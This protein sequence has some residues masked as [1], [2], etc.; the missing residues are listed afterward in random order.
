MTI[1]RIA[2]LLFL[3]ILQL[4]PAPARAAAPPYDKVAPYDLNA[5]G[6]P[7]FINTN[8]IDLAEVDQLTKFRSDAGHDYSDLTQFNVEGVPDLASK[9]NR[10]SCRSMKHYFYGPDKGTP[11]YAP[12]AGTVT[13]ISE[14][15]VANDVQIG[16]QPDAEPAFGI[17]IFHIV[18]DKPL[19]VGQHLNE[20]QLIGTD[21]GAPYIATDI[22]V[23]VKTPQGLHLISYFQ[24]L[25]DA[26]FAPYKARGVA[27][28]DALI[29]TKEQRD[30]A[31]YTCA[32]GFAFTPP[33]PD[34][35]L[36]Y[37]ALSGSAASQTISW[38]YIPAF[39]HVSDPPLVIS[40]TA[41]SGQPVTIST[42]TPNAC[43]VSGASVTAVAAGVCNILLTQAGI[44]DQLHAVSY[45][46]NITVL[47]G[48]NPGPVYSSVQA[49][50]QSYLRFYNTGAAAGTVA[51]T[52]FDSTSGQSL[53]K[54]ISPSIPAGAEQQYP[55]STL[56]SALSPG[57]V[58]PQY[59]SLL[60]Q[61][62]FT[63]FFQHVLW[64][65]T[66]GVYT[67]LTACAYGA[68]SDPLSLSGVHTSLIGAT[69]NPSS[70]VVANMGPDAAVAL[71]IYDA[72]SGTMLGTYKTATIPNNGRAIVDVA[73][74]EAAMNITPTPGMIHY[75]VKVEGP[76]NGFLQHLV[77]NQKLGVT[78][79]M[80]RQCTLDGSTNPL[81][82]SLP[83][84]LQL[85]LVY[86]SAN[87][88]S[89]SY[90][91]IRNLGGAP[92]TVIVTLSDPASG[93]PLGQ[94][95]SPAIPGKYNYAQQFSVA[96]MESAL[97]ANAVKPAYYALAIQSNF[98][99]EIQHLVWNPAAGAITNL[100]TCSTAFSTRPKEVASVDSSLVSGYPSTVIVNSVG[101]ASAT[102]TYSIPAY[103]GDGLSNKDYLGG[104]VYQSSLP[105]AANGAL[106]LDTK[107]LEA[108]FAS[109]PV[110][111]YWY[112]V[113]ISNLNDPPPPWFLENIVT[114][115]QSGVIED[116]TARCQLY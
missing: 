56:E 68:G 90:L 32:N 29:Y 108:T 34:P 94:W 36:D 77:L 93:Q 81:S 38:T 105:V 12:V 16:I 2:A 5:L 13:S 15:N 95:T 10:E 65:P 69:G 11:M 85:G 47:A 48:L 27:S 73:A 80:T 1:N 26:A 61:A 37:V 83:T 104:P 49:D 8:F 3:S 107:T 113:T 53:G 64:R 75:V 70:I 63:G 84:P 21:P 86:S 30:A 40:A 74:M 88:A 25:T 50:L 35:N 44:L 98:D 67:N 45:Q 111:V 6:V 55:I 51:V 7:K 46:I 109:K 19:V 31:P 110:G 54:W 97:P 14:P 18:L 20:G 41:S 28:P 91:R 22:A 116:A 89:Q 58:K 24:A 101:F 71:D 106:F 103:A 57:A 76:L 100:S 112:T 52:L 60:V 43:T 4:L 102:N 87:P 62:G 42:T 96:A 72:R 33:S 23:F 114:S 92:G 39:I 99:G 66:E 79:D 82:V 59:Y 78:T 17:N 9:Y 115:Q